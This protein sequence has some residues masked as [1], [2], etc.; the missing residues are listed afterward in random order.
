MENSKPGENG[1]NCSAV[2]DIKIGQM[3]SVLQFTYS[4]MHTKCNFDSL[5]F[6]K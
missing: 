5:L 6:I 1:L 4:L 2:G 3:F